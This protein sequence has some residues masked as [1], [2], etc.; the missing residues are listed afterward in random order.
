LE[1]EE[2]LLKHLEDG[3]NIHRDFEKLLYPRGDD[4]FRRKR[5]VKTNQQKSKTNL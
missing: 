4:G 2:F 5:E 3:F 1:D